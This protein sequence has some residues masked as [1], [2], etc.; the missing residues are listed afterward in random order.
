MLTCQTLEKNLEDYLQA[1]F[2]YVHIFF[3]NHFFDQQNTQCK[4]QMIL[5]SICKFDTTNLSVFIIQ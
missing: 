1:C 3:Y 5:S 2:Y 4:M